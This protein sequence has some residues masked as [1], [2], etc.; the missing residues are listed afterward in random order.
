LGEGVGV[1][2]RGATL[3]SNIYNTRKV[4]ILTTM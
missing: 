2:G 1:G 3:Y 4:N